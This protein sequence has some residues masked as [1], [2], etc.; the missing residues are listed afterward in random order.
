MKISVFGLGYVGAVTAACLAKEGH[1]VI[2]VDVAAGKVDLINAGQSPLLEEG[3]SE[4]IADEVKAGRLSATTDIEKAVNDSDM[5]LVC[6]GTPSQPNG[7]LDDRYIRQVIGEIGELIAKRDSPFLIVVR[8]TVTPGTMTDLVIPLLE[9]TTGRSAGDG[10]DVAFHPEFLREGSSIADFYAPPKIV[11][12]ERVPGSGDAVLELYGEHIVAPRIVCELPVAETVKYCDNLFHA[13]KITFANEIG[14]MCKSL[15]IDGISAMEIFCQDRKLNI[16]NKYLM[17]GFAFG[18]SCLPKDLR[19]FTALAQSQDIKLPMLESL[20]PSN[21]LQIEYAINEILKTGAKKVGFHGLA[22]KKGTDDL[23]ESPYVELAERLLGKG[24]DLVF[25]D[26]LVHD[27]RLIGGNKAYVE[28]RL[29]HLADLLTS[30]T[31]D[32]NECDLILICHQPSEESLTHWQ[33]AG[34]RTIDLTGIRLKK[35]SE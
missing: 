10:Y 9:S 3:I 12:G 13:L 22:F 14:L 35:D 34:V 4:L 6:V 26:E 2:G 25:Y 33:E 28:Q 31:E 27:S 5:A 32:L 21:V 29:P 23:R 11:V 15:G 1:T 24:K 18:G 16:S 20:L 7:S 30:S 8:S 19:A 17:P